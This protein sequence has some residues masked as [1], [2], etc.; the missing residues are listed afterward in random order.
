[1]AK[2]KKLE[3]LLASLD[4]LRPDPSSKTAIA[5]LGKILQ[6]PHSVAVAQAA[7]II[8]GAEI[9]QLV[10]DLVQAFDRSMIKP[11]QTDP[12]C[13]AKD[14]LTEA[15]Y[16]MG[17]SETRIFLAG[18]HHQQ[19]EPVYGG[20]VDTAA[21]LRGTA[22]LGLTR[23]AYPDLWLELGD[24]LGDPEPEARIGA[25]RAI[26]YSGDDRGLPLLRLRARLEDRGDVLAEYCAA[27]IQLSPS[28]SVDFVASF[29]HHGRGEVQELVALVLGESRAPEALVPLQTYWKHTRVQELRR[30]ALLAI[31]LLRCDRGVNFLLDLIGTGAEQDAKGAISA[32]APYYQDPNLWPQVVQRVEKRGHLDWLGP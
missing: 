24:L 31:A 13:L 23:S 12:N 3:T 9:A 11:I 18:I 20:K 5:E 10:P 16:H 19:W 2:S 29:L 17:C 7:K 30:T 8:R 6:S 32:L 14:S 28:R 15:L 26:A 22:A 27:L 4:R 1:M 25:A 21:K